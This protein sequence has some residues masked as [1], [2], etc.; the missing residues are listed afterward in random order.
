MR[1]QSLIVRGEFDPSAAVIAINKAFQK[2]K[3]SKPSL[4]WDKIARAAY[5]L[6]SSVPM[7]SNYHDK[8]LDLATS[9]CDMS[10]L[11]LQSP[12][13]R[14][15]RRHAEDA[16]WL[17]RGFRGSADRRKTIG[18]LARTRYSSDLADLGGDVLL[19]EVSHS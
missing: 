13:D 5:G 18:D 10:A 9:A 14:F 17:L 12:G 19:T 16:L 8:E 15:E 6:F 7:S 3:R 2:E 11:L 1:H 4:D